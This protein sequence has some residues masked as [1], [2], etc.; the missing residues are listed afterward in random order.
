M[1]QRL[2]DDGDTLLVGNIQTIPSGTGL[3]IGPL[4]HATA[5]PEDFTKE[6]IHF[7]GYLNDKKLTVGLRLDLLYRTQVLVFRTLMLSGFIVVLTMLAFG[8]FLSERSLR[9]LKEIET[10][11]S[12]TSEGASGVRISERGGSSQIDRIARQMNEHFDRLSRMIATTRNKA[13]A[14]AHDLKSPLGRAYLS[15]E[16][17][18]SLAERNE[19]PTDALADTQSELENMRVIFES[20]LQLSR[21][22]AAGTENLTTRVDLRELAIEMVDTFA[23]IAEDAGQSAQIEV[24]E[25]QD[26]LVMGDGQMLQQ[27]MANLVEN[28]VTHGPE[29]NVIFVRLSS[30]GTHIFL[31]VADRGAGIPDDSKER[32]FEPFHRLDESR[33][34][35]GSGLGLAPVRAIVEKHRGSVALK[36]DHPGLIVEVSLPAFAD[37]DGRQDHV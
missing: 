16:R 21:I 13:A 23:P 14:T 20:Y 35:P 34:K 15:L 9:R 3:Q 28:A 6:Y 7:T 2:F 33:S 27:L 12:L 4:D 11:L 17:A 31:T 22:E 19:D 18:T 36:D 24:E 1:Q 30:A 37:K 8:Y 10:A 25:G 5:S 32:A 29:G 26:F